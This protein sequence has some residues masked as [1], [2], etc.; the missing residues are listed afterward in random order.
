MTVNRPIFTCK[1]DR[2]RVLISV[3][4]VS[5]H[6]I[7]RLRTKL[8]YNNYLRIYPESLHNIIP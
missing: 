4:N 2:D 7:G 1:S 8:E 3:R 5:D 6:I